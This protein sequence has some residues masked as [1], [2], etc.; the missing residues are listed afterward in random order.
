MSPAIRRGLAQVLLPASILPVIVLGPG[1]VRSPETLWRR[2]S[3][4]V[5]RLSEGGGGGRAAHHRRG[6]AVHVTSAPEAAAKA[7]RGTAQR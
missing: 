3:A 1:L 6:A 5:Q 4:E 7:A 2:V